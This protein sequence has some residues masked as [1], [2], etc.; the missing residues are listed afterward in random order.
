MYRYQVS[1][2]RCQ[3][4]EKS[5]ILNTEHWNLSH[6][7]LWFVIWNFY[8]SNTPKQLTIFTGKAWSWT[9]PWRPDF[10]RLNKKAA[11]QGLPRLSKH[12]H[13][14]YGINTCAQPPRSPWW[15]NNN[16]RKMNRTVVSLLPL[17]YISNESAK[18]DYTVGKVKLLFWVHGP[19]QFTHNYAK[20][21]YLGPPTGSAVR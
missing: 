9:G 21:A 2:F 7:E 19:W 10:L 14:S 17:D 11:A 20:L 6:C 5:W 8:S 3:G 4:K 16:S 18:L 13:N 1:G 12:I 15:R